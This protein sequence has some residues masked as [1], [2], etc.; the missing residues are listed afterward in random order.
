MDARP[1]ERKFSLLRE[2]PGSMYSEGRPQAASLNKGLMASVE[3]AGISR[4]PMKCAGQ[5]FSAFL[6][7]QIK[8]V[9]RIQLFSP[10]W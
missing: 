6:F 1:K 7:R 4:Y 2:F 5:D 3:E 10:F 8:V 9:P